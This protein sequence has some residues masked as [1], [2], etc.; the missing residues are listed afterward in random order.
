MSGLVS[1]GER[2]DEVGAYGVA[3]RPRRDHSAAGRDALA[4]LIGRRFAVSAG[5][6][7]V[8]RHLWR[9]SEDTWQ[10]RELV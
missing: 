3:G 8:F 9:T 2:R 7:V 10:R 1:V 4:L 5:H 6:G